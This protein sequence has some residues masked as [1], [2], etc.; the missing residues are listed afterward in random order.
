[1]NI[2]L[3]YK[4]EHAKINNT[5]INYL[6]DEAKL[7]GINLELK[8]YE[9]LDK[10][11]LPDAIINR[12]NDYTLAKYYE[13]LNVRV[14]N[15]SYLSKIANDKNL[16]YKLMKKNDIR[17]LDIYEEIDNIDSFPVVCKNPFGRGGNEVYLVNSKQEVE[18]L[19]QKFPSLTIQ[20]FLK[21]SSKDLRVYVIN[22]KIVASLLR[23][24]HNDFRANYSISKDATIYNLTSVQKEYV[25]KIINLFKIDYA[26]VDFLV[27]EN[28]TLYFNE[29]EDSVGARALYTITDINIAKLYIN[30]IYNQLKNRD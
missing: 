22:N 29:I 23:K 12:T 30:H 14:F 17:I 13:D 28:E 5:F 2:F 6:I 11:I 1:M 7:L 18:K 9:D 8:Y 27:D 4:K 24:G 10:K 16:A 26:G 19:K 20:K 15:N 3:I 25:Y 21:N